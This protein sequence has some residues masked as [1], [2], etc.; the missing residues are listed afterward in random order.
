MKIKEFYKNHKKKIIGTALAIPTII[1]TYSGTEG[2]FSPIYNVKVGKSYGINLGIVTKYLP[3]SK[4][5]GISFSLLNIQEGGTINGAN[6]NVVNRETE[7]PDK[8]VN[9]LE[10]SLANVYNIS[11]EKS[12]KVVNGLQVAV[13][14]NVTQEVNGAQ[15]SII[16]NI[17]KNNGVQI[18]LTNF[19]NNSNNSAQIGV[20]NQINLPNDK[21]KRGILLNYHFKGRSKK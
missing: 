12:N 15:I 14:L 18:G 8:K 5:N 16:G 2:G 9:G 19:N 10:L 1:G 17:S 7:V 11:E 21:K 20:Y 6:I 13:L 3:G 4:H